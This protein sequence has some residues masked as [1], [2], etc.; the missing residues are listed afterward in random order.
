MCI[1]CQ[2]IN[3][4][5]PSYKVYEDI[6]TIAFLDINPITDGHVLLLPKYHTQ[7]IENLPLEVIDALFK[8]MIKILPPINRAMKVTDSNITINNGPNAGQIIPHVHIHVIPRPTKLVG[9]ASK[10]NQPH[11]NEYFFEIMK[12]IKKEITISR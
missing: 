8:T 9:L 12:K 3:S 11:N 2:I 7:Y 10:R 1:F 6:Y 5:A 4:K